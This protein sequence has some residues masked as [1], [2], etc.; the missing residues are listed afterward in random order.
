[1]DYGPLVSARVLL[2]VPTLGQRLSLL[3][4][5]L[6]SI[7]SQGVPVDVVI[8]G[9]LENEPLV[10]LA[11]EFGAHV[12]PD[13]GSQAAAINSGAAQA[14]AH[15]EFVNWLGDDDLLTPNSLIDTVSVLDA[16]PEAVVAFGC[17]D[18]LTESGVRIWT[19]RA[20]RLAPHLLSWG[21][22]L[23]PQ[24]GMLVRVSAWKS[25]GGVDESLRFAFDLD[26]LLKL[27]QRGS[28]VCTDTTVSCFRWHPDSLTVSDRSASLSESEAVKRRH[29]SSQARRWAWIWEKPVRGATRLA[30]R[31]VNRQ[32]QR[33]MASKTA[34]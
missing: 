11:R 5:T 28:F 33:A 24:P 19:S 13:P 1:M 14:N 29:L 6:S 16:N 27:R 23:I 25:V 26:L 20:G 22:D 4:E 34:G 17:C 21:P 3:K 10:E 12:L 32:A 31:R 2:V 9:P 7:E 15:H 8:V 30:A 18:Y